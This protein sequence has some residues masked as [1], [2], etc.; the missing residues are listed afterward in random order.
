MQRVRMSLPYFKELGWEPVVICVDEKY[1]E[2]NLDPLLN[3][4]IPADVEVH[5][6][7]AFPAKLTRKFGLGSLSMRSL[8]H[9]LRKGNQLLKADKFDLIYFSTTAFHVCA[10]GTYWKSKFRVPFII[11][12]QDPWRS[13]FYLDKPKS[14]RP[15]KFF[16]AYTI[17][18][19]LEARTIPKVDGIISVSKGYCTTFLE[20]YTNLTEDQFRVIPFGAMPYDFT[21]VDKYVKS[22]PHV[23]LPPD[24]KNMIY[25]GRGGF[26]MQYALKI[27][28]SAFKKG[29]Q[30]N[31]TL[32]NQ[33]HI[34]FIGTSY[35][36]A[37]VGMKTIEP[38]AKSFEIE[39]HVTE[40]PDRIPYFETLYLLKHADMLLVPGSTDISY[41]ASKIY[42]YLLVGKP[43]LAVF[44]KESSV[45]DVLEDVQ[46][47]KMVKFDQRNDYEMYTDECLQYMSLLVTT[48]EDYVVNPDTF[49]AYTA[50]KK[51]EE[52]VNFFNKIV[53]DTKKHEQKASLA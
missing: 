11:D 26:D 43:L 50:K 30:A 7:K 18:K 40:L 53:G 5:K 34:S 20:R 13:D 46:I 35:A 14:E 6:V 1:V 42:P 12:V 51:T 32:F 27:I 29:L 10:L 39:D 25:I 37:G 36:A 16:I 2:G 41:T 28:F 21:I 48:E 52:Q 15:P 22:S 3:H 44:A 9:F 38:V 24:K 8:F 47:G 19:Y 49:T 4:T 17:D 33:I 45:V 31:P 23:K